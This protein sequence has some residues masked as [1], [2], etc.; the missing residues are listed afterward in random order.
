MNVERIDMSIAEDL[1]AQLAKEVAGCRGDVIVDMESVSFIDSSGLSA[2]VR[3][4]KSVES[5]S[6]VKLHNTKNFVAKVLRLTK[7]D[8]V[9][10]I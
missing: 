4:K 7:M 5:G 3:L 1:A 9:F 6:K 8:E 10:E 2:L